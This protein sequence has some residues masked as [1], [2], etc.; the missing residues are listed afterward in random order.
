MQTASP[1]GLTFIN[2][3]IDGGASALRILE[4]RVTAVGA[5]PEPGDL[6]IDLQGDRLLPG[7]IN[8]HDHLQLNNFGRLKYR[9]RYANVRDWIADVD[10]HV[11][12]NPTLRACRE[13]S[14]DQR[15]LLGAVKNILAG[16]TTVAHHD[17]LYEYLTSDAYP[18]Q[19]V[20]EYGWSHSLLIDG[21]ERVRQS[22]QRTPVAWPWIIHAAEGLDEEAA[23]EFERLHALGCIGGNTL[24]VHGVAL[25][26]SQRERLVEAGAGL[27]WCP[28]S[29]LHLF[30]KT[31]EVT[32]L[33]SH[34]RV[35]LGTDSRLSGARDLLS[36]LGVAREVSGLDEKTLES[37]ATTSSAR[38]L[39][40]ADRGVLKAGAAADILVLPQMPL[41]RAT[42]T[43]VRLV[44]IAGRM[45]YGDAHYARAVASASQSVQ[46]T[47]D[48]RSKVMDR[49]LATLLALSGVHEPGLDV[50]EAAAW[51][52][53]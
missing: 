45:L 3:V 21:E 29:N 31:A 9:R 1:R 15:L 6:V 13:V 20:T 23:A 5:N 34:G 39:R 28:A 25:D 52:A 24:I 38:L 46:V 53:A 16:V 43:D 18:M 33:V 27:I 12:A 49:R 17:P 7:L 11:P 10:A 41:S 32:D 51:R 19:A 37:L 35:A 44:M 14:R 48:G 4:S 22:Y 30:G 42:R 50:S 2:A 40:L 26:H 36:E 47:V 8:A